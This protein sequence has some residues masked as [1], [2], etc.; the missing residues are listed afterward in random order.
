M[1]DKGLHK[2]FLSIV[3]PSILAIGLFILAIFVV[4]L[5]SFEKTIMDKKKEMISELTNTA[6]SL[7][8]EYDLEYRD[9]SMT[10][11]EAQQMAAS[12]IERIRYGKELKDYFWIIDEHPR[13][14]MHPYRSELINADLTDYKDPNGKKLFVEAV[15]KV[16]ADSD[17]FVDYMWQWKDDSTQIVPK[18]SYV[19]GYEPWNWIVGT[20]IYLEDVKIEIKVLK[21]RLLKVSFVITLIISI[22]LLFVMRQSLI[23][24]NKRRRAVT[25]LVLSRQKYK[26]LV[27]A[28]TEGTLMVLKGRIIFSN[29][30][31]SNLIGYDNVQLSSLS[32]NQ[33]FNS[34]WEK[35]IAKIDD[36]KKSIS[37]E[38]QAICADKCEKDV[39]ISVSQ[40]KYADEV[41]FIIIVKEISRLKQIEKE[42]KHLS[43]ELQ[44]SLLLMNQPI[45]SFVKDIIKCSVD[46]KIRDAA[47][48]MTRK[49]S[50]IIF[51]HKDKDIIGVI[52]DSDLKKRVL[53]DNLDTDRPVM[54]IMTAPV[55]TISKNAL[56]YEAFLLVK[57]KQISHVG[58]VDE[59]GEL[60]GAVSSEDISDMHQNSVSYLIKEIEIAEHLDQIR[61]IHDRLP[62]LVNAL[63]ESGDKTQ[64]ITRIITSVSD[65]IIQRIIQLALENMGNP[66]CTFTFMVMGSEGRMEQT[67]S[68]DQ[69]NAI[70]FEDIEEDKL[71][72]AY[73][74]FNKLG[75][76][77]STNLDFV[78]FRFC[79]GDVMASNQKWTQPWSVWRDYFTNWI[80]TSEPQSILDASIFFDFRCVY[81]DDSMV[82]NLRNH[83]NLTLKDK[84]I[85]YY[86]LAQSVTKYK[87]PLSLFGNIIGDST[88]D[89]INLDVKKVILPIIGFIRLYALK[90][91]VTETNSLARVRQLYHQKVID[92]SMYDELVLSYNYLMQI[93]FRFQ[94]SGITQN[95]QPD[96]LVDIKKLT[97]IEVATIKKILSE[98]GNLQTKLHFDF[99]GT[100]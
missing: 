2:F 23:I 45:R 60:F 64:N 14:I 74:Y 46:T 37:I 35:V 18:L 79:K 56:L 65:A 19:K 93:R 100:T 66:P 62:I 88:K 76:Q 7:L 32:F 94:A 86:H 61:K 68:T 41:G 53:A 38:T 57:N 71:P 6:Y 72:E 51:V 75:L 69:D 59:A 89:E 77:V 87:P 12:R 29:L 58:V 20:G 9:S 95:K 33:V 36:P 34:E 52:N 50:K 98:I 43:Q 91:Q 96:N 54:E 13:M 48:H 97:H 42:T 26:S 44:T 1:P 16:K 27:E 67:L 40:I 49:G 25:E 11:S 83:I 15:Y 5:P 73:S 30:K 90:N 47:A 28:S 17:G 84:S 81:G 63:I 3:I 99:K 85:F 31:F 8:E 24:E 39:V 92:K 70:V 80:N 4:I 10:L 22:T 55:V 21:N 82:N 78:G